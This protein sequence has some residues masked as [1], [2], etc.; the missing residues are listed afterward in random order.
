MNFLIIGL[1]RSRTAWLAN[2]LT[3]DQTLCY[4]DKLADC[5]TFNDL[6]GM[7]SHKILGDADTG[8][9][10]FPDQVNAWD[11][12]KVIIR[13]N[14]DDVCHSLFCKGLQPH[15]MREL[16]KK[17]DRIKADLVVPY[18]DINEALPD[19]WHTCFYDFHYDIE[20]ANMMKQLYIVDNSLM[21]VPTHLFSLVQEV[22]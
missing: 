17:L 9:G 13:R 8:L 5:T 11:I 3:T 10:L 12:T 1:P 18:K 7:Y 14:V 22:T 21:Q 15:G 19:I 16:D 2:F 20:R 4:H 6:K